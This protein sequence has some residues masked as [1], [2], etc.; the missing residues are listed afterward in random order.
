MKSGLVIWGFMI[1]GSHVSKRLAGP[2]TVFKSMFAEK[3]PL[4]GFL[5]VELINESGSILSRE[6]LA[7][8]RS[9]WK[10]CSKDL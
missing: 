5:K 4:F 9:F 8:E 10:T 1:K 6:A 2:F 3:N 7:A